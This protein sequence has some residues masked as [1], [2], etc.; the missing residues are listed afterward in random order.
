MKIIRNKL[1]ALLQQILP[2]RQLLKELQSQNQRTVVVKVHLTNRRV[3][4]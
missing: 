4:L 3:L 2:I 1:Q